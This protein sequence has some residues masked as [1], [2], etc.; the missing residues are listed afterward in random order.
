[1]RSPT[2]ACIMDD[3]EN[4]QF[5]SKIV[6]LE[7]MAK[8][9]SQCVRPFDALYTHTNFKTMGS[10]VVCNEFSQ[11]RHECTSAH[12]IHVGHIQAAVIERTAVISAFRCSRRPST[13]TSSNMYF[14][15]KVGR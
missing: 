1:M 15:L 13:Y 3:G 11:I 10:L 7:F 9:G 8:G 2:H 14:G 5:L 12:S 6:R 4:E